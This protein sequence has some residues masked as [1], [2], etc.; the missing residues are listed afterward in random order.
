MPG[1]SKY[2]DERVLN[3]I[4]GGPD[5]KRPGTVYVALCEGD[6]TDNHTGRTLPESSYEKYERAAIPNDPDHWV[7][8]EDGRKHNATIIQFPRASGGTS[9]LTHFAI[10][11]AQKGGN[12]IASGVLAQAFAI[13]E[14]MRPEF[15]PKDITIIMH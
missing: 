14:N 11:D 12:I 10:L 6:V 1:F 13:Q 2:L 3:H 15:D 7:A 5:F 8:S 9:L 4:L